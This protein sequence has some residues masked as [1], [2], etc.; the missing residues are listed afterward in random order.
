[1]VVV[2]NGTVRR[3][4]LAVLMGGPKGLNGTRIAIPEGFTEYHVAVPRL[5]PTISVT[6]A[7]DWCRMDRLEVAIYRRDT[8][9]ISM[10]H[11][12]NF[13]GMRE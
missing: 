6:E 13:V 3:C 8:V 2:E 12:W 5:L 7:V 4:E 1:M 10:G 11:V 9:A